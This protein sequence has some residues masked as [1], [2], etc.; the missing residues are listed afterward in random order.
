MNR[1]GSLAISAVVVLIAVLTVIGVDRYGKGS[2]TFGYVGTLQDPQV[3]K[4]LV[5]RPEE[6]YR[7]WKGRGVRGRSVLFVSDQWEKL[8]VDEI[9]IDPPMSRPYPLQLYRIPEV[10]EQQHLS[11][12][13]FLYV[14]SLNGIAR[15]IVAV[16]DD[17]GYAHMLEAA[18]SAK[19]SSISGGETYITHEGF[20]R[21]FTTA[22]GFKGSSEPVLLYLSAAYFRT[23]DPDRL[24]QQLSAKGLRSDCIILCKKS[25]DPGIGGKEL[26]RLRRFAQLVGLSD[27]QGAPVP[28]VSGQKTGAQ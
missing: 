2:R 19:N 23:G 5:D 1:T 17:A 21:W 11:G 27:P 20:P 7:L 22:S 28:S 12:S 10:Q 25:G 8:T 18:R 24:F 6:A 4:F 3:A 9:N 15:R 14:A 16:L 13:T 26:E